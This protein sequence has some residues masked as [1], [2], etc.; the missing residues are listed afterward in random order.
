VSLRL[1]TVAPASPWEDAVLE[2]HAV[3]DEVDGG[4][5]PS[6]GEGGGASRLESVLAAR[7]WLGLAVLVAVAMVAAWQLRFVQDDA[8]ISFR[9][10]RNLA[11]GHGLVY[12]PGDRVQGFTNP[13][14][15]LLMV[16]PHALGWDVVVFS[17]LSGI[18]CLGVTVGVTYRLGR[19]LLGSWTRALVAVVVLVGTVSFTAYGTG[20]LETSLQ[21]ALVTV[22][23]LLASRI[24]RRRGAGRGELLAISVT[25]GLAM[26]TRL[27]AALLVGTWSALV[28]VALAR[29]APSRPR[30][31]AVGD[32][33]LLGAPAL[34]LVGAWSVWAHGFYGSV[35][36]NT[37]VA[38]RGGWASLEFGVQYLVLFVVSYGLVTLLPAARSQRHALARSASWRC[39]LAVVAVWLLYLLW[40]GGDFMEFRFM[41]PV[42]PLLACLVALLLCELGRRRQVGVVVVLTV[43]S[44]L[45]LVL[46]PPVW[47]SSFSS[48]ESQVGASPDWVSWTEIGERLAVTFPG[49]PEQPDQVVIAVS[50]AGVMPYVS[51]LPTVD[52]LGLND[53]W[54]AAHGETLDDRPGHRVR[55]PIAHLERRGVNLLID[56]PV[57]VPRGERARYAAADVG[58]LTAGRVSRS[59]L[60]AGAQVLELAIDGDRA[61]ATLLLRSS[62][63]IEA[64]AA[65][66]D[67]RLVP[68]GPA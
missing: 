14:W 45:H 61:V 49:G 29:G 10:A 12:Q 60:P 27:D 9:Y 19:L 62:A 68:I 56:T 5:S 4:I 6:T 44:A 32:A 23:A 65:A 30:R 55:A 67:V 48:L 59:E 28:L 47:V 25:A 24:I 18:A 11:E 63:R 37:F 21:T 46:S 54:V 33:V 20:G 35:L 53:A 50:A 40:A 22:V 13:L 39:V 41:V 52:I 31:R 15:T 66:G 57:E 64:A 43:C 1:E 58:V 26:L 17:Q 2:V 8:F 38:K 34:L 3:D 36:P 16:I 51:D 7:P 42:L